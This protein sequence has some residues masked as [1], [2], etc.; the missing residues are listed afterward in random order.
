MIS[1]LNEFQGVVQAKT[2]PTDGH[3][4]MIT[5]PSNVDGGAGDGHGMRII[6]DPGPDDGHSHSVFISS[7][8]LTQFHKGATVAVT[9]GPGN[10]DGDR[11]LGR[12]DREPHTHSLTFDRT[13]E[14]PIDPRVDTEEGSVND[15]GKLPL[16]RA[17]QRKRKKK[18]TGGTFV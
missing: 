14:P 7:E 18:P 16:T 2:G 8:D 4:H 13:M 1:T 3:T 17:G 10:H 11:G 5:I 6:T 12:P 15:L 9:S